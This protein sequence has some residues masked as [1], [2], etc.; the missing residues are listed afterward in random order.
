M[1]PR[2][3]GVSEGAGERARLDLRV[4]AAAARAPEDFAPED[5]ELVVVGAE[6]EDA[7]R[8]RAVDGGFV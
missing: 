6:R 2:R 1:S 4:A 7:V 3:A 8:V 5:V